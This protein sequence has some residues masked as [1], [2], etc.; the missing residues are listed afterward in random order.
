MDRYFLCK[1]KSSQRDRAAAGDYRER[2]AFSM[3]NFWNESEPVQSNYNIGR[4]IKQLLNTERAG[5]FIEH[6]LS[7]GFYRY[8]SD[9]SIELH[10]LFYSVGQFVDDYRGQKLALSLLLLKVWAEFRGKKLGWT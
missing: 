3:F 4:I 10:V 9:M 7:V 8:I 5:D 2:I 6:G 1:L